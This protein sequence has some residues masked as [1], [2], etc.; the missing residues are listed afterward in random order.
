MIVRDFGACTEVCSNQYALNLYTLA[1]SVSARRVLE[2]GAG[3][4]WSSRAFSLSLENRLPS[5]LV[6][7]DINPKRI[8]RENRR[9]V[10]NTEI[11]WAIQ[12]AD[13][14]KV[15]LDGEFDVLY[16][17]GDPYIAQADFLKFY[18]QVKPGGLVIMDG[19]NGQIGPTEAVDSLSSSY[20]FVTLPYHSG[21]AHAV[22][23][24]PKPLLDKDGFTAICEECQ[25]VTPFRDWREVDT[26]ARKHT[27]EKKHRVHVRVEPRDLS[28][29]VIPK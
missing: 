18:P 16:I 22:H 21:Y 20:P 13:S 9:A 29:T 15:S 11:C 2:I 17:D 1:E 4:G 14:T 6:S 25:S 8:H 27:N 28:Y 24:K 19:Y 7:V 12:D 5:E 26:E 3:W 23:R 10:L